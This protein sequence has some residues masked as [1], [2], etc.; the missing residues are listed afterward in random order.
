ME[1]GKLRIY[2][3]SVLAGFAALVVYLVVFYGAAVL[4][5]LRPKPALPEGAGYISASTLDIP[6]GPILAGA[7][8]VTGG[9]AFWA[10]RKA[11][12]AE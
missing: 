12:R 8:L 9:A 3:K 11:S 10:Y 1:T 4:Y 5:L 6:L 7:F 2:M